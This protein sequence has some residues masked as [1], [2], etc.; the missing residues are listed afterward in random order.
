MSQGTGGG[1]HFCS[2]MSCGL[3]K[4]TKRKQKE[5]EGRLEEEHLQS[6]DVQRRNAMF[7]IFEID[8]QL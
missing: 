8:P 4:T 2:Q 7:N 1:G 5:K 6:A 3:K